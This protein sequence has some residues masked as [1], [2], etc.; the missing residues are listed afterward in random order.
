M[1][2]PLRKLKSIK[3]DVMNTIGV[4]LAMSFIRDYHWK[5]EGTG[6]YVYETSHGNVLVYSDEDAIYVTWDDT[7]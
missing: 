1:Y 2:N 6:Q 7:D 4:D 5:K 3:A